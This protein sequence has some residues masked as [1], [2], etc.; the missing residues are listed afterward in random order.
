MHPERDLRNPSRIKVMRIYQLSMT[1]DRSID[2]RMANNPARKRLERVRLDFP[3]L[4]Q[5][6]QHLIE[7]RRPSA[8]NNIRPP[9]LRLKSLLRTSVILP[10][11]K[12]RHN[13]I[14]SR[15]PGMERLCVAA[16]H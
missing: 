12:R 14:R 2:R 6:P 13:P 10:C 3:S 15:S 11:Q 16:E 7:L 4:A 5:T 1:L 8:S 9:S